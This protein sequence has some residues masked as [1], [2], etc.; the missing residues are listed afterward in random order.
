MLSCK[1]AL[2]FDQ[3]PAQPMSFSSAHRWFCSFSDFGANS[4]GERDLD[5]EV[6]ETT[7]VLCVSM[8]YRLQKN[9]LASVKMRWANF[10]T[11]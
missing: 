5:S 4:Q 6:L 11:D 1:K 9:G 3:S 7:G 8:Y 2:G 10:K